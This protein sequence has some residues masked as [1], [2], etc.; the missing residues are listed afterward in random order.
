MDIG[1]LE[2]MVG[3]FI[4]SSVAPST[5]R[6]YAT[7]Q[8]RYL[9]FCKSAVFTPLPATEHQLCL[10][11]AHLVEGGLQHSSIKGYLSAIRRLQIIG[12]LGDPFTASWPLLECTLKGIKREQARSRATRSCSRLPVTPPILRLLRRFW[13]KELHNPDC[14]MLWAACCTCFFGFLRSGEVTVPSLKDYDA[15]GHLSEGDVT[16]DSV[17]KPSVVRVVIKASKTDPFR[18]GVAV[19][20]GKTDNDLC[21]VAALTAYMAVRGRSP[22]PFFRFTSRVP[23]SREQLVKRMREAL[24]PSG[25]DV[26]KYSGH[27]FRIGAATVAAAVGVEDSLIKTLGRWQSSAYLLYVRI[28]R[29][30]LTAVSKRLAAV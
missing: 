1:R 25:M 22:G 18:K 28:P 23:L 21:P 20:L 7:G 30:R 26:S 17:T 19:Y 2:E 13:E 14:I 15:E 24:Q 3:S 11:V 6:V 12:G 29:E 4:D 16:L 9:A 8:R 27:S 10:F 5:A